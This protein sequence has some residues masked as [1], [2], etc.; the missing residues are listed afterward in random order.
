MKVFND[1]ADFSHDEIRD[2]LAL[3]DRLHKNPEPTALQGKVLS[4]LFLSP[5]LRTMASFQAASPRFIR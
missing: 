3:A 4:M 2:L 1:L 5:S